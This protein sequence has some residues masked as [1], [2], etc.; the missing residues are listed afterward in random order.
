MADLAIR[1]IGMSIGYGQ[2]VCT[3][4]SFELQQGQSLLVTGH[5][6][7]GKTTL[8]RTLFALM[9]MLGGSCELLGIDATRADPETLMRAG[10]RF[11]GQGGRSFDGLS[12]KRSREALRMLYHFQNTGRQRETANG[13]PPS[14]RLGS[15]SI[16]QRRME[17]LRLLMSGNPH[18]YLLDEPLAGVDTSHEHHLLDWIISEQRRRTSFVI[19]EQRFRRLLPFCEVTMVLRSGRIAYLG[20]SSELLDEKKATEVLL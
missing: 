15:L 10:A 3:D 5:N 17:A 6:G 7:T 12:V 18:L 8:L 1:A 16:G 13:Y 19:V 14:A 4:I 9:P 20:P 11:L 2:P